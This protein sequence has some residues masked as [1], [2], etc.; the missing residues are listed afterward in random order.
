M[1]NGTIRQAMENWFS[2]LERYADDFPAKG[3]IGGALVVLE[4]LKQNFALDVDAHT[5]GGGSQIKGASGAAVTKILASLGETRPFIKEGG[6]TNRGLR[7][8]IK[9]L[10]EILRGLELEGMDLETRFEALT[11]CQRFLV[12]KVVEFHGKKRLA[13]DYLPS[14]STCQLVADILSKAR[15]AGKEGA[16]AQYLIGAKLALRFPDLEISNESSSTA[17]DQ[18]GRQGDFHLGDTVFHVTVA[19]MQPV[20]E[21]CRQNIANGLRPMLLVPVRCLIGARQSIENMLGDAPVMVVD[22]ETFIGQNLEELSKFSSAGRSSGFKALL[23]IYNHRV[24]TIEYDKSLQ[25]DIPH[26]LR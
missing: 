25:I 10:L 3:T 17:D 18:S 7:G 11:N 14:R 2:N 15:D 16:V 19:P 26:G 24:D 6:R 8:D 23:E 5:A 1:L 21:K 20:Y 9:S 4:A 13:F 22:I 12:E